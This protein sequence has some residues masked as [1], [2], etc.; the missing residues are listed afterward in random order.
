[1]PIIDILYLIDDIFYGDYQKCSLD[2]AVF[3]VG[4][5]RTGSTNLQR[6]IHL[7]EKRF[8]SPRC[9]EVMYPY[10]WMAIF[11]DWLEERDPKI[12][13]KIEKTIQGALGEDIMARH[14]FSWYGAEEDDIFPAAWHDVGWYTGAIFAHP[15]AMIYSGLQDKLPEAAQKRTYEFYILPCKRSCIVGG[16]VAL[17]LPRIIWLILCLFCQRSCRMQNLLTSSG[18]Q[19]THSVHGMRCLNRRKRFFLGHHFQRKLQSLLI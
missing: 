16:M 19:R 9:Y 10:L 15:E 18:T 6:A 2:D 7:D 8:V 13:K 14:P 4:G 3:I 11:F 5:F 12:I 1:M 17:F